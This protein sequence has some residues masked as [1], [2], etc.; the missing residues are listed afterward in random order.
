MFMYKPIQKLDILYANCTAI[1]MIVHLFFSMCHRTKKCSKCERTI[2][3]WAYKLRAWFP[4]C[5]KGA[6]TFPPCCL[7][8]SAQYAI[9]NRL[10]SHKK[11]PA[12]SPSSNLSLVTPGDSDLNE[13]KKRAPN[14]TCVYTEDNQSKLIETSSCQPPTGSSQKQHYPNEI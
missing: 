12:F 8:P 13:S 2:C 6:Y 10:S 11:A 1:C 9:D 3:W 5:L 7:V 14:H 4:S